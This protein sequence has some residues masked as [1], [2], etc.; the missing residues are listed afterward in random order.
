[1][2][3]PIQ[4]QRQTDGSRKQP[5]TDQVVASAVSRK[6]RVV[7]ELV[8]RQGEPVLA[9]RD[10]AEGDRKGRGT[11]EPQIQR[12]TAS[13]LRPDEGQGSGGLPTVRLAPGTQL[14][15]LEESPYARGN[16]LFGGRALRVGVRAM[17]AAFLII[18]ATIYGFNP[19][20]AP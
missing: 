9:T 2:A 13:Y 5:R 6:D 14:F 8:S 7:D 19:F 20:A 12:Q 18:V 4:G 16:R 1:M 15:R 17:W 11:R 3:M 10:D